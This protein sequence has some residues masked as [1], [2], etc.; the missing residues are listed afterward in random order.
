MIRVFPLRAGRQRRSPSPQRRVLTALLFALGVARGASNPF[1]PLTSAEI[2]QA[3]SIVRASGRAP[4]GS[5][6]SLVALK[7]PPKDAVLKQTATPRRA[8]V[9]LYN[10]PN[11]QT[12][13]GVVNLA[14]NSLES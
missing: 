10:Y 3:A 11:N 13:E 4:A 2:R 5:Q 6:F 12:F 1:L 14:G 7:E 9:V 8:S